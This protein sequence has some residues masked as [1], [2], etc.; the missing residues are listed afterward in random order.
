MNTFEQFHREKKANRLAMA[1]LAAHIPADDAR[2]MDT[3]QWRMA[4]EKAGCHLPS[5]VT[6]GLVIQRLAEVEH[7]A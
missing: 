7:H 5:K 2:R 6:I 1:L 4:A 3:D